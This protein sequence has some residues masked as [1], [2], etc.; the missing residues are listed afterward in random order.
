MRLHKNKQRTVVTRLAIYL[1]LL[2]FL[3]TL[4]PLSQVSAATNDCSDPS[5]AAGGQGLGDCQK[6]V[7]DLNIYTF[8]VAVSAGDSTCSAS[9]TLS[10]SGNEEKIWNYY[11][12]QGLKPVAVAGIMG[13]F[14]QED[15]TFDP[16]MKQNGTTKSIPSN[17]DGK[18]GF[19]I[20]QWTYQARQALLF[21]E[22]QK[23]GLQKY[24]GEGWGNAE[25]DKDIPPADNDKLLSIELNFSWSGDSTKIKDIAS[26]L[27]ATTSTTGDNG[28]AVL[29]HKLYEGSGDTAGQIQER[30]T[31]ASD[32]L[33]KYSGA[34][35]GG[36]CSTGQLG[37]VSTVNDA[38]PWAM[39]FVSDTTAKY[40][41][42]GHTISKVQK[43]DGLELHFTNDGAVGNGGGCWGALYCGQCTALSG[44]F[45]TNETEYTF[46]NGSGGEVVGNLKAKGVPTGSVPKP[47]SV[48]SYS[49]SSSNGHTGVVMG[50]LSDGT[51][52]TIEN[53]YTEAN[54]LS[55]RKYNIKKEH[56]DATFAYVGNKLK[57][58]G[59]NTS[60]GSTN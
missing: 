2:L 30:V 42:G 60:P 20:A 15:S 22:I 23:A 26:Q 50:V 36:S 28:S 37:G 31:S 13:N 59:I 47:Y 18:T 54:V 46:G 7:Y 14:V 34:G 44:W 39:K 38:I 1:V 33:K 17:G 6:Q 51:V 12:G 32:I 57:V 3:C 40:H 48:F 19:G 10:G 41:P 52:I 29:F 53:N 43:G 49:S 5:S 27:N 16:A 58:A 8:D 56:P 25:V 45:V 55:I 24:Y 35:G 21:A 4:T 9:A 11:S